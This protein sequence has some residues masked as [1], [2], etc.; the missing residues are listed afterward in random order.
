[1]EILQ[2]IVSGMVQK[3]IANGQLTKINSGLVYQSILDVS[4]KDYKVVVDVDTIGASL[5]IYLG[6]STTIIKL[7]CKYF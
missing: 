5:T 4:V 3:T 6:G 2:L 1:M 7:R